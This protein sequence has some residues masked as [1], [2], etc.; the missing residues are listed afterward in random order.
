MPKRKHNET[1][2]LEV[3][4]L[5]QF[6]TTM[7]V[8]ATIVAQFGS[9]CQASLYELR[10]G[11]AQMRASLGHVM[12]IPHGSRLPAALLDKF[13]QETRNRAP[14]LQFTGSTPDG[15]RLS[16]S[17]TAITDASS[18]EEIGLLKIDY[19][20][21]HLISSID[22]LQTYCGIEGQPRAEE[23][24][25]DDDIGRLVDG[26]IAE[27][28]TNKGGRERLSGKEYRLDIVRRL[29]DKD[30]FRVKGSVEIVSG[31]LNVSKYSIYNYLD[32]VRRARPTR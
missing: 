18:G 26:I 16:S 15:R 25:T 28:F 32:Q 11:V 1:V 13:R 31:R 12:E 2:Q 21:E 9:N 6:D 20:I 22:V 30:V 4:E 17:L 8:M 23:P 19:C 24:S 27:A 10:D 14:R 5:P 29:E 3:R 7:N